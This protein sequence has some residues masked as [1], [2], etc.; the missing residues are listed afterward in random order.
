[1]RVALPAATPDTDLRMPCE[2][3]LHACKCAVVLVI[4]RSTG[5]AASEFKKSR[6]CSNTRHNQSDVPRKRLI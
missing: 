2:V 1:M 6:V 5:Q 4:A 3:I